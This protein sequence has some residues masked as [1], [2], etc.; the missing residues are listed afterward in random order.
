MKKAYK[1]SVKKYHKNCALMNVRCVRSRTY[2]H[3][4]NL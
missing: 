1:E 2:V 4:T 3:D